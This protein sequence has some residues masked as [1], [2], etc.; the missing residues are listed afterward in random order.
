M[1]REIALIICFVYIEIAGTL[2][3]V[4]QHEKPS[5]LTIEHATE[6]DN[7]YIWAIFHYLPWPIS[8]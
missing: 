5:L 2:H 4:N 3:L 6:Y 7:T 8:I 1:V